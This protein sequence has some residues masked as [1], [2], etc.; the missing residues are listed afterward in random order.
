MIKSMKQT[1]LGWV[2]W[3]FTQVSVS[4]IDY[5]MR[6]RDG[7]IHTGQ[8]S[9]TVI[10]IATVI[11]GIAAIYYF[12]LGTKYFKTVL[13]VT[14]VIFESLFAFILATWLSLIYVCST[15]IDCL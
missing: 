1:L 6:M 13:R 8:L 11:S 7:N 10:I 14:I 15:G 9:E 3:I 2:L 5:L 4:G 12:Y